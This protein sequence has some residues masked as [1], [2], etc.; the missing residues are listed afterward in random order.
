VFGIVK[1]QFMILQHPMHLRRLELIENVFLT[2][3]VLHNVLIDYDG[4]NDWEEREEMNDIEDVG[5]AI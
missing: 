2:C 3:T 1:K 4:H 5:I